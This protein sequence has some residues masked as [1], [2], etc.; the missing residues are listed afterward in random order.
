MPSSL[1]SL[2]SEGQSPPHAFSSATPK[3]G[4]RTRLN[5]SES[6]YTTDSQAAAVMYVPEQLLS[7]RAIRGG[8]VEEKINT[9]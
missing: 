2:I 7:E 8:S 9:V 6:L 5:T 3:Q 1:L 4:K